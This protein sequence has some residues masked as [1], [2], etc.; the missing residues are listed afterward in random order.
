MQVAKSQGQDSQEGRTGRPIVGLGGRPSPVPR[1]PVT[2]VPLEP[3]FVFQ[4]PSHCVGVSALAQRPAHD[5]SW[6]AKVV[7]CSW[8]SLFVF[9][10]QQALKGTPDLT[11]QSRP[12]NLSLPQAGK[13][14]KP[15]REEAGDGGGQTLGLAG[16]QMRGPTYGI[17]VAGLGDAKSA[18]ATTSPRLRGSHATKEK[19]QLLVRSLP[20]SSR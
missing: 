15:R 4:R 1:V 18:L 20:N 6:G 13:V 9:L 12:A 17:D 5:F 7:C 8:L 19:S 11:I 14:E 16:L 2:Q 10:W 3:L